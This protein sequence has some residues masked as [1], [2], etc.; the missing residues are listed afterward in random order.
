MQAAP[1]YGRGMEL[2][3]ALRRLL[4]DPVVRLSSWGLDR[5]LPQRRR[6]RAAERESAQQARILSE[7]IAQNG[8][9]V[10]TGPFAGLRL[11]RGACRAGV[12]AVLVGSYEEEL[13][14]L[15]EELIAEGP[16]RIVNVGCGEGYYAAGFARRLPNSVVHAFDIDPESQHLAQQTAR[17]NG[18]AERVQVHGSC[19]PERLEQLICGHTL[20]FLDC[21]GCELA[22]LRPDRVPSLRDATVLVEFHDFVVPGISSKIVAR[23]SATHFAEIIAVRR[24][25]H[26]DYPALAQLARSDR[27]A[28]TRE[29][30]PTKPHAMEWALLRPRS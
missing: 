4:P 23:F 26:S 22:L 13:H 16:R 25:R 10:Q 6:V 30:R 24:R 3:S 1:A 9:I 29:F 5:S 27:R 11:P 20:V 19:T 18:L 17:L 21:E 8:A 2:K 12:A 14:D 15:I 7:L 28:A